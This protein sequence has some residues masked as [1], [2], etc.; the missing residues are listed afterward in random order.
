MLLTM[1]D[2][3]GSRRG[4]RVKVA[5]IAT[6]ETT[7][8]YAGN[9]AMCTVRDIS[10]T[11][12]GLE[13]GQP[14][15]PGQVVR[16]RLALGNRTFVLRTLAT[17]VERRPGSNF[18]SVGLDWSKCAPEELAF[19]DEVLQSVEAQEQKHASPRSTGPAAPPGAAAGAPTKP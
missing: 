16:L 12:I 10:R 19:L 7:G 1:S 4:E 5:A 9:Q 6:L 11:G 17:R 13:T 18:Y 2:R 14:P 15:M 8:R 3:R